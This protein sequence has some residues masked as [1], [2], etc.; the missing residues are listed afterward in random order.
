M[1]GSLRNH[2]GDTPEE[3]WEPLSSHDNAPPDLFN[4]L[5]EVAEEFLALPTPEPLFEEIQNDA[6]KAHAAF[7]ALNGSDF[8]DETAIVEFLETAYEVIVDYDIPGEPEIF[9]QL[10]RQFISKYNLRYRLDDPFRLRFLLPGSFTNLYSELQRMNSTN[11]HLSGLLQD[12]E[13]AFDRYARSQDA[14][15]LKTCIAKASNYAEGLASTT[16]GTPGTLGALCNQIGDWPHDKVKEALQSLY[17]F[18]SDYP[19]IRH[20]GSPS[21]MLRPLSS[22][23]S[24]LVCLL[25]IGFT[26]YLSPLLDERSVLGV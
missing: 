14:A 13:H 11:G 15:D 12:F 1:S 5:Y 9:K 8:R 7:C 22:K 21:G 18:C 25:L 6:V 2:W 24:T 10:L 17:K 20:A 23:D 19:G 16:H 4:N 3:I 26:G